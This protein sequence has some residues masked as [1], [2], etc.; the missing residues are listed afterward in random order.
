MKTTTT[1]PITAEEFDEKFDNGED[2]MQYLDMENA[3]V[4]VRFLL[5]VKLRKK[6][7]AKAKK[8]NKTLEELIVSILEANEK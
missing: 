2:I 7:L 1:K 4:S 5:P 3:S 8:Q 6:L